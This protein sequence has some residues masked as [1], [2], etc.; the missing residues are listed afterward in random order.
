M[1]YSQEQILWLIENVEGN[2]W[3]KITV[4]FNER[5]RTD[6]KERAL[7]SYCNRTLKIYTNRQTKFKTGHTPWNKGIDKSEWETHFTDQSMSRIRSTQIHKGERI[8]TVSSI[9]DV[10][11]A[12]KSCVIIKTNNGHYGNKQGW[13]R[14]DFVVWEKQTGVK[15]KRGSVMVHLDGNIDNCDFSNLYLTNKQ[16]FSAVLN[17]YIDARIDAEVLKTAIMC[18]ELK[19]MLN[20]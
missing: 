10:S 7:K 16:T 12:N 19:Q 17:G 13:E 2:E 8:G 18:E 20:N 11:K 6:K 3:K 15:P 14:L 5:F 1:S 9:G 4:A